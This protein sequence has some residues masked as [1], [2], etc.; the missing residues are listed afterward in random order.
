M[1]REQI[2][3]KALRAYAGSARSL[4]VKSWPGQS[5]LCVSQKVWTSAVHDAIRGGK[6]HMLKYLKVWLVWL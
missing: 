2:V 1:T 6:D 5:V 4:W 3:R